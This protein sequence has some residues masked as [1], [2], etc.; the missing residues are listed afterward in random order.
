FVEIAQAVRASGFSIEELRYLLREQAD[1]VGRYRDDPSLTLGLVATLAAGIQQIDRDHPRPEDPAT[2]DDEAL[3]QALALVLPADALDT[4]M[5]MWGGSMQ[6]TATKTNV[7]ASKALEQADMSAYP[8]V[9][10][11]DANTK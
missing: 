6:W 2:F 3:R 9:V 4:F 7:A 8:I 5:G 11:Y 1:P 10:S